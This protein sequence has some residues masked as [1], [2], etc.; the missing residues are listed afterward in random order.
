MSYA[1]FI[2]LLTALSSKNPLQN[3]K[4]LGISGPIPNINLP[5]KDRLALLFVRLDKNFLLF[6]AILHPISFSKANRVGG[7]KD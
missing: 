6:G 3:E 4:A 1:G 7:V 2:V 5:R